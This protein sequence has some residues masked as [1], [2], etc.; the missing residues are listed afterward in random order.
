M[1]IRGAGTATRTGATRVLEPDPH[2]DFDQLRKQLLIGCA[3]NFYQSK[4][5][6][7]NAPPSAQFTPDFLPNRAP[8]WAE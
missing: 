6:V 4:K 2:A 5:K 3:S 8:L 7:E 1:H